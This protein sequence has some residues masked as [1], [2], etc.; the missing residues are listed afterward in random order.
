MKKTNLLKG[1]LSVLA[2]SVLLAS[3][4]QVDSRIDTVDTLETPSVK[5]VAY[6]GVNYISWN[7]VKGAVGYKVS[8]TVDGEAETII[9]TLNTKDVLCVTDSLSVNDVDVE[10]KVY[11]LS[12]RNPSSRAVYVYDSNAGSA[13]VTNIFPPVG[14]KAIDLPKYEKDS[15]WD[16]D[17]D[18]D[19][20]EW[21]D[22]FIPTAENIK[23]QLVDGNINVTAPTKAYLTTKVIGYTG[24][25]EEIFY[26][27]DY[28]RGSAYFSGY[29]NKMLSVKSVI[30]TAGEY[31]FKATVN[32]FG[33]GLDNKG[34]NHAYYEQSQIE[35]NTTITIPA[36]ETSKATGAPEV[37][38]I[39]N[40]QTTARVVFTPAV[41]KDGT[42]FAVG[43]Y[44]VYRALKGSNELVEVKGLDEKGVKE[45]SRTNNFKTEVIYVVEDKVPS[46]KVEYDYY[47]V[48]NVNG[49]YEDKD[50]KYTLS[51]ANPDT[52]NSGDIDFR[53]AKFDDD[54]LYND[55]VADVTPNN[56]KIVSVAYALSTINDR[57]KVLDSAY[58]P[59]VVV[60]ELAEKG[61]S[62]L[63]EN[64]PE[65]NYVF[66]K[67][68][69][70]DIK[71]TGNVNCVV[72]KTSKEYTVSKATVNINIS[73][74]SQRTGD[75]DLL[76]NDLIGNKI[77]VNG[78]DGG[79]IVSVKYGSAKDSELAKVNAIN[80]KPVT[81]KVI[82]YNQG[83]GGY[84][85]NFDIIDA[86][87]VVGEYIA[88]A[89]EV[90]AEGKTN[91]LDVKAS[92][93]PVL[94]NE[95]YLPLS[96]DYTTTSTFDDK[97][98]KTTN[99]LK[100]DISKYFDGV[101]KYTVPGNYKGVEISYIKTNSDY[102]ISND[103]KWIA[104]KT[105]NFSDFKPVDRKDG[106]T[107]LGVDYSATEILKTETYSISARTPVREY[108]VYKIV[109]KYNVPGAEDKENY[110]PVEFIYYK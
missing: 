58:K 75:T 100:V 45:D 108:Y 81:F 5:A 20:S 93:K 47:V 15:G 70:A 101:E 52:A 25:K 76:L 85:Y 89:V 98:S 68:E 40:E 41:S 39:D 110:K 14:T 109:A 13:S 63:I 56:S 28:S 91:Y 43:N 51:A 26:R 53:F 104:V 106:E 37:A 2:V 8:R 1:A 97:T 79:K 72:V 27:D 67:A 74:L 86:S 80:G 84:N 42:T 30:R 19:N 92:N 71:S 24:N 11:A 3:C 44:K 48:L 77:N 35:L 7:A 31:K 12:D 73:E 90:E 23:V 78:V 62:F 16:F 57:S 4:T 99:I 32:A 21:K 6:P 65:N 38:Y 96:I 50:I 34:L 82:D 102:Q 36:V 69:F 54:E 61:Q 64:V 105:I 59:L 60:P 88:I 18:A 22:D 33:E 17:E 95:K 49:E 9:N 107:I 103:A 46:N 83:N 94:V 10:Y 66:V 29:Q 87:K 55:V